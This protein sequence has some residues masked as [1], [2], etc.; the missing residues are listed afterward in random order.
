MLEIKILTPYSK[1]SYGKGWQLLKVDTLL[2]GKAGKRQAT[3]IELWSKQRSEEAA[4]ANF[5]VASSLR[6]QPHVK[7]ESL[8]D[9]WLWSPAFGRFTYM[10]GYGFRSPYG[11][12]Y[13]AVRD[14]FVIGGVMLGHDHRPGIANTTTATDPTIASPPATVSPNPQA[15]R[16]APPAK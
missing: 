10:P 12:Q 14:I 2:A 5:E 1:T 8:F 4:R 3:P 13:L 6:E 16:P 9:V 7:M 11:R 15:P